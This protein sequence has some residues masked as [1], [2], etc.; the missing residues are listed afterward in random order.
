VLDSLSAREKAAV[1]YY[2][3]QIRSGNTSGNPVWVDEF[4]AHVFWGFRPHEEVVDVG[5]HTGRFV[6]LLPVLGIS[7][8]L[9]IDPSVESVEYCKRT[10]TSTEEC[11]V[12]FEV[13]EARLLGDKYPGR[14]AGFI[15]TA[16]MMHIPRI[17]LPTALR[18]IRKCVKSGSPGFFSTPLAAEGEGREAM[19]RVGLE[20]SLYTETELDEA[21]AKAGFKF[22]RRR[23]GGGMIVGHVYAI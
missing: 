15:M 3:D 4:S 5:C 16:V 21:F 1:A 23:F 12:T 22:Y 20:I 13:G 2:D 18:S 17:D 9:G 14:F 7:K 6:P 10:F 19:S 11:L 8:Y